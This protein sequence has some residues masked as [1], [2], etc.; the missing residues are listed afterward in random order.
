MK[1]QWTES[2]GTVLHPERIKQ[3]ASNITVLWETEEMN[4]LLAL[5]SMTEGAEQPLYSDYEKFRA[6]CQMMPHLKGHPV[7]RYCADFL[8][9]YF[10]CTLPMDA[11]HCDTIWRETSDFLL[12]HPLSVADVI[13]GGGDVNRLLWSTE[14]LPEQLPSGITPELT[15]DAL[16][17]LCCVD[18]SHWSVAIKGLLDR[19]FEIGCD[20]ILFS[21]ADDFSFQ[22]PDLYHVNAVIA[23]QRLD[24]AE[25]DLLL[26]QLF[27]M[28]CALCA[29][30]GR[31]IHLRVGNCTDAVV[32]LL[33][34]TEKAVGLPALYWST[35]SP[36]T[37]DALLSFGYTMHQNAVCPMLCLCDYP[38]DAE[39]Q[40]AISAYA[41][42]YPVGMLQAS[43]GADLRMT[44]TEKLRFS[45]ILENIK[46]E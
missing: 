32:S 24:K 44:E 34:Y 41:A 21:F 8:K 31:K 13:G 30:C 37:R 16:M 35:E 3:P 2:Y 11:A 40:N 36:K 39:L 7:K 15:A 42:R 43:C 23:K 22:A 33:T 18:A 1:D 25:K 5:W 29:E 38:S 26:S 46:D 45:S 4:R 28:T 20:R 27:R 17:K 14:V 6:L 12:L 19:F 10:N 9:R